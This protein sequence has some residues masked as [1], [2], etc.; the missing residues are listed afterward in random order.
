MVDKS[1]IKNLPTQPGVYLMY[2]KDGKVIYV[3]KAVVLKNRVSQYFNNSPKQ[4]KVEAMV[5]NIADFSYVIT[6]SES[7]A[8]ALESNLIKKYKPYYNILLK[9]DKSDPYIKI[10]LTEEYPS[11]EITRK[12]KNDKNKYF[13]PYFNG[14]RAKDVV[15][16]ARTVFGV[17]SCP[18]K[19]KKNKR[20]C[21]NYDIGLC[22]GC[23]VGNI[24]K[25]EYAQIIK[26]VMRFLSGY[27]EGAQEIIEEKMLACARNEDFENAIKYRDR[28][29]MLKQ[30]KSRTIA[31]MG[32]VTDVDCFAYASDGTYAVMSVAIV[33]GNKMMGVKNYSISS[34]AMDRADAYS[35]FL[36][37]YYVT[38]AQVPKEI[39]FAEEIDITALES[40]IKL[41]SPSVV[42]SFPKI[43]TRNRIAEMARRN[44]SDY[45]VKSVEKSQKE[46]AMTVLSCSRLAQLLGI[47]SASRI[48]CYDISNVSGTDKVASGVCF[49][50]GVAQKSEYRRYKIKTVVGA[51]DF[52][53]MAE[54]IK[55][56]FEKIKDGAPMPDL[57]VVDGGKG[58]LSSALEAM[59]GV[60]Y[61]V[62][63]IALAKKREEIFV[64]GKSD[65]IV[66]F[67]DDNIVKLLQRVRDEAHRFA[68]T[69]HRNLRSKTFTSEL[70]K[71]PN[72]G[73]KYRDVLLGAF[74]S[75]EQIR[76][77]T[78]SDLE[79]VSGLNKR[80]AR[81]V[82][83]YYKE[84]KDE[85]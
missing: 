40:Y 22:K 2:D 46:E 14:I 48:E 73:K 35:D 74:K 16:V 71:I 49:I 52:A 45:L 81:S 6:L 15:E 3:G 42:L 19:L 85:V 38:G 36:A 28:L 55:R 70:T 51:D 43:G 84:Q 69:Y 39:D 8:L 4:K 24:S 12:L 32:A 68:V 13:G 26:Q 76:N 37:Q 21:L 67:R 9:D 25:E 17:R 54:V 50:D 65:P 18:K 1:K 63:M 62:P 56:R 7:D 72:V 29:E 75:L 77:A 11:I 78:L 53:S 31:N 61:N 82:Y 44:A 20:A 27:D 79:G 34:V 30:L 57:I 33:R 80:V 5:S 23:C 59:R 58:Q 41:L 10:N 64:E 66:L 47:K 83:E 60:G